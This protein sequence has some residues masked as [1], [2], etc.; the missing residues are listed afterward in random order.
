MNKVEKT[1]VAVYRVLVE[2]PDGVKGEQLDALIDKYG[3]AHAYRMHA[4]K[5]LR[6][7]GVQVHATKARQHSVWRLDPDDPSAAAWHMRVLREAYS[8]LLSTYRAMVNALAGTNGQAAVSLA[9][10]NA[11]AISTG[12]QLYGP[13]PQGYARVGEDLQEIPVSPEVKRQMQAVMAGGTI[14][15]P[16]PPESGEE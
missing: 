9:A 12:L 3:G 16:T 6:N 7:A 14:S 11:V 10:L 2:N 15:F 5:L 8:Q 4:V 13:T 1:A